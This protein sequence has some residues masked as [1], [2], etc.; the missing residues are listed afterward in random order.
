MKRLAKK[1]RQRYHYSLILL[2]ELVRTDFKLRYQNSVLGYLWSLLRPLFMFIILFIIFTKFLHIGDKVPHWSVA[3]FLG[4]VMWEFFNEVT[5][6]GLKAVVNKGGLIRK[7]NFPKYIII[8]SSSL[9]ALINLALNLVVVAIFIIITKA[10]VSWGY[11][12][13]P[14]YI[15][16]LYIFALGC[17]FILSTMYVKFRDINF[18]WEI[19]TRAGF[20]ATA[21]IFPMSRIFDASHLAGV[22]LLFSPVAQ[23]INDARSSLLGNKIIPSTMTD[24]NNDLLIIVPLGLV[25]FFVLFGAWYFRSRSAY[26]AE[27]V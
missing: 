8:V 10:P 6:Q 22:V 15:L 23:S 17:A 26:F 4:L 19:V 9:S 16:E 1:A 2:K 20:Y 7:I 18:V 11:L 24:L 25:L 12:L 27:D 13:I 3:L 5:K 21:V 14:L